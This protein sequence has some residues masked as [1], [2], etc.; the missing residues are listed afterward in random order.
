MANEVFW[1]DIATGVTDYFT[2]RNAARQMWNTD[3]DGPAFEALDPTHWYNA[4]VTSANYWI[5][6]TETPASSYFFVGN[7]PATLATVGWYYVDIYRRVGATPAITDK[8]TGRLV[9][10]YGYW[11][12]TKFEPAG[13]D[14]Q[15]WKGAEASATLVAAVLAATIESN[16]TLKQSL[17]L[18]AAVLYGKTS[19]AGNVATFR[20]TADAADRVVATMTGS[21]RTT[22]TLTP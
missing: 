20:N 5:A 8:A 13:S 10:L 9:T 19:I 2:I 7:W 22:M 12:G 14:V 3:T 18:M 21:Q 16:L 11:D 17:E 15:Q 1:D 6:L 4:A